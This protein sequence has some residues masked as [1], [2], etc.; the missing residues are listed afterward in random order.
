MIRSIVR[1]ASKNDYRF[2]SLVLGIIK[3]PQF[4]TNMKLTE[5]KTREIA[6]RE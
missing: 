6:G 4:Q 1:D 3:S 5:S 2:S